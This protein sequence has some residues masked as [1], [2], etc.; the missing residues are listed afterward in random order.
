MNKTVDDIPYLCCVADTKE[1]YGFDTPKF[2]DWETKVK[3]E[4]AESN[5]ENYEEWLIDKFIPLYDG[6]PTTDIE[7]ISLPKVFKTKSLNKI[8][9]IS[10]LSRQCSM[11]ISINTHKNLVLVL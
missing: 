7:I 5:S 4:F 9:R 1:F 2:K 3:K 10:E 8:K 6:N 11:D